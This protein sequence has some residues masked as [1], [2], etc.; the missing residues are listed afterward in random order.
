MRAL[1]LICVAAVFSST[2]CKP[3]EQTPQVDLAAERAALMNTD[4]AWSES[5]PDVEKIL[6]FYAEGAFFLPANAPIAQ[7][8]EAIRAT[9]TKQFFG[10]GVSLTWKPTTAQVSESADLGYTIGT[11]QRT[12]NDA[13]G[14]PVTTVGKYL[15]AWRKQADGQWKVVADCFNS[16]APPTGSQQ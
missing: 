11:Y 1:V 16:D 5:M 6:A 13:K 7:G 9:L 8:K 2:G 12:I 14:N 10:P 15:T 4:R 3:Q